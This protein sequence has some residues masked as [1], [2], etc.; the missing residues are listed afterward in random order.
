[1]RLWNA[2]EIKQ[3]EKN[4]TADLSAY[5]LLNPNQGSL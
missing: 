1:M 5:Q 2:K 4:I 3:V